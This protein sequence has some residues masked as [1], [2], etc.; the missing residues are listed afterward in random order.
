MSRSFARTAVLA[1]TVVALAGGGATAA[2]A[3]SD[4]PAPGSTECTNLVNVQTGVVAAQKTVADDQDALNAA[5]RANPISDAAVNAARAKLATDQANL[6][7]IVLNVTRSLCTGTT[8][9]KPTTTTPAPTETTSPP[10]VPAPRIIFVPGYRDCGDF[11]SQAAAQA[12]FLA[13]GGS[14]LRNINGLDGNHNGIACE[15][16]VYGPATVVVPVPSSPVTSKTVNPTAD[17]GSVASTSGSQ[18]SEV[19]SGSASTGAA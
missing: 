6:A 14:A 13:N 10:V 8:T 15:N 12:F 17:D 9:P 5:L 2:L 16:T 3:A 18:V 19:P 4:A 7:N 11:P 1:A